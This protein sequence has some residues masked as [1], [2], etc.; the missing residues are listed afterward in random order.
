MLGLGYALRTFA[1]VGSRDHLASMPDVVVYQCRDLDRDQVRDRVEVGVGEGLLDTLIEE[2]VCRHIGNVSRVSL[3]GTAGEHAEDAT[4]GVTDDRPG[5]P[6]GGESAVL[7]T[8]GV[9]GD[10]HRRR[11]NGII[12]IFTNE[13]FDAGRATEGDTGGGTVLDDDE[14]VFSIFVE[15]GRAAQ[16]AIVDEVS[17]LHEAAMRILELGAGLG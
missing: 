9:D 11:V 1:I 12:L 5:V 3:A 16:L 13:R 6:G 14:T 17:K 8:V 2:V 10:L 15:H 7:V 4:V